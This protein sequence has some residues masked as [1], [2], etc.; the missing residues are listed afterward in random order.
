[1]NFDLHFVLHQE[2]PQNTIQNKRECKRK[3]RTSCLIHDIPSISTTEKQSVIWKKN[4]N[5]LFQERLFNKRKEKRKDLE[6]RKW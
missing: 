6:E 3:P 5:H 2:L 4:L 1:M